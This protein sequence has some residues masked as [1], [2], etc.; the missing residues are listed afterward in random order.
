MSLPR[1][2]PCA[3]CRT[4]GGNEPVREWLKALP[5]AERQQVGGEIKAVQYGWPLG[6]PLVASLGNGLREVRSRRLSQIA[7]TIFSAPR[8]D[9]PAALHYQ[10]DPHD[11]CSRTRFSQEERT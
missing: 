3:C 7:R 4:S 1:P 6:L 5:E 8:S 10:K 2:L 11:R 9:C